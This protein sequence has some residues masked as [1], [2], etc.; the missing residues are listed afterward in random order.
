MPRFLPVTQ[1][2]ARR[3]A[4]MVGPPSPLHGDAVAKGAR[5]TSSSRT[6]L[7]GCLRGTPKVS[8]DAARMRQRRSRNPPF[9]DGQHIVIG[10]SFVY[11]AGQG[12]RRRNG[13]P[14]RTIMSALVQDQ[15]PSSPGASPQLNSFS[16]N[17]NI[18]R[19]VVPADLVARS[20]PSGHS[21]PIVHTRQKLKRAHPYRNLVVA[22]SVVLVAL[23]GQIIAV[24]C[25]IEAGRNAGH[26]LVCPVVGGGK[27]ARTICYWEK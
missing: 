7:P 10:R 2:A 1:C 9:C 6:K 19:I 16:I 25:S 23:F 8:T 5:V 14:R 18:P 11:W 26:H 20:R 17:E 24:Y 15:C 21:V 3:S 4:K 12:G 22:S 13:K 27:G